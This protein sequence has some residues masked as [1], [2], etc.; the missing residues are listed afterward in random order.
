[1]VTDKEATLLPKYVVV[2]KGNAKGGS[3]LPMRPFD[4]TIE[5]DAYINACV[6]MILMFSKSKVDE[7][8]VRK[9]FLVEKTP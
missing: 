3:D 4:T 7:S 8:A 9:E 5:C 6:D 2:W 1:M